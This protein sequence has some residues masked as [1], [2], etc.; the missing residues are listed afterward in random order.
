MNHVSPECHA[1][2]GHYED[3]KLLAYP[4]PGSV[5]GNPWTIGRGHTG[6]EVRRGLVW[7]QAQADAAFV[8]DMAEAERDVNKLLDGRVIPQ[9]QFDALCSF[10]FNVGSD[11]D[12]DNVAEGLGDST[13][14]KKFIAGDVVGAANEFLKWNKND[15]RVMHG[16]TKRRTAERAMFLGASAQSAIALGERVARPLQ[17]TQG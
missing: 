11:I 12:L 6:P 5:D 7:T 15:G 14:F 9:S 4:D 3:C 1:L 16:L 10:A 13:L 2:A 17:S 8:V